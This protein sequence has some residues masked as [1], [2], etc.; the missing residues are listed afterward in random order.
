MESKITQSRFIESIRPLNARF[1]KSSVGFKDSI[2][3]ECAEVAILGRSNVGKSSFINTLLNHKLAKSSSTPGKTRLINFFKVDFEV[4]ILDF[5]ADSKNFIESNLKDSIKNIESSPCK[6]ADSKQSQTLKIPLIIIDFPGFG[7]AKVDKKTR[8]LWDKNLSDFLAK[9]LSVKLFCHLIDA[10]HRELEIDSNIAHFL[11]STLKN[12]QR[13]D[14]EII[15]IYTKAD[16]LK[17]NELATL[18]HQN[19]LTISTIKKDSKNLQEIYKIILIKT[20]GI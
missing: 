13:I 16:K 20:L 5:N 9:R 1:I 12:Q 10:R 19:A 14:Y 7:Y 8:N 17:K 18:R 3:A 4:K 2:P 11:E 6:N 15:N